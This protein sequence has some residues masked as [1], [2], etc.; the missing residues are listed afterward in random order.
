VN[1]ISS[2]R[3]S[4]Q[5]ERNRQA[6]YRF[7]DEA[8]TPGNFDL[9]DELVASDY[10]MHGPLG[11]LD[12]EALKALMR[13]LRN[14]FTGF[15]MTREQVLVEHEYA[16]TRTTFSGVFEHD[17]HGP[18]GLVPPT[19]KDFKLEVLNMFRFDAAGKIAEEWLQFDN[20][21]FLTQLG[22]MPP[23]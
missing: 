14:A 21:S 12:L 8:I 13:P 9:L 18:N 23:P 15:K 17:F 2:P 16:S 11:D 6:L 7:S 3:V 19:G 20:L 10:V 4:E 1:S 5:T 22:V